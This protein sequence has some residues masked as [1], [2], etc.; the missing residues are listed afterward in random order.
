MG[1]VSMVKYSSLATIEEEP[2]G[3]DVMDS[4]KSA[5]ADNVTPTSVE[6]R[7]LFQSFLEVGQEYYAFLERSNVVK[8]VD[9][10]H[11]KERASPSTTKRMG[12]VSMVKYRSLATIK[13]EPEEEEPDGYDVTDSAKSALAENVTSTPVENS[14]SI[15]IKQLFWNGVANVTDRAETFV[16]CCMTE[17]KP[18]VTLMAEVMETLGLYPVS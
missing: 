17:F 2:D 3:S 8:Y 18:A 1:K 10:E 13:E 6:S 7:T 15:S 11:A 12:K 5:P 16:E 4:P 14:N 9:S